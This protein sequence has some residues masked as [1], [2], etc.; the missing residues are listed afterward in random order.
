MPH[1]GRQFV[2]ERSECS[3]LLGSA[4][5]KVKR[6]ES[7]TVVRLHL[8]VRLTNPSLPDNHLVNPTTALP[9]FRGIDPQRLALRAVF[10]WQ[11]RY[12]SG[13]D[14]FRTDRSGKRVLCGQLPHCG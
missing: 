10:E 7:H 9:R 4:F 2:E 8:A 3:A 11:S 12:V 14:R 13:Q 1:T 5:P 6:K